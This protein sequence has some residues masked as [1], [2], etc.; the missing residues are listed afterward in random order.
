MFKKA[1][2]LTICLPILHLAFVFQVKAEEINLVV[3]GNGDSSSNEASVQNNNTTTVTQTNTADISNNVDVDANTGGNTVSDN[4]GGNTDIQ[5]GNIDS[6][7]AINNQ[8]INN[9]IALADPCCQGASIDAQISGNGYNSTNSIYSTVNNVTNIYQ[10]NYANIY[11]NIVINGN[12]GK[13]SASDNNGNVSILT[14]NIYVTTNITNKNINGSQASGGNVYSS[15]YAVIKGNGTE[16]DNSIDVN[17]DNTTEL[18]SNNYAN[19]INDVEHNLNTGGN[20]ANG[21]VGDVTIVTGDIVSDILILNENIN[22]NIALVS[23]LICDKPDGED[24]PTPPTPPTPPVI[25]PPA[26][27][28]CTSNCSI[29]QPSSGSSGPATGAASGTQLPATGSLL[30]LLLT[31]SLFVLFLSGLYL[32]YHSGIAPPVKA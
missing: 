11:N 27:N 23:C 21:N 8:D 31:L 18:Y 6:S 28:G 25:P 4:T 3:T 22:S 14:G 20:F 7:T 19:M 10:T 13:N 2:L 29:V 15:L 24:P 9:N 16:S 26:S 30:T 32:R 1:V 17:Q 12:T 5:T